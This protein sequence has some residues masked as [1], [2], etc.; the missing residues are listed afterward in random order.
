MKK[1]LLGLVGFVVVVCAVG[2]FVLF[3]KKPAQR[4]PSAETIAA[5]PELVARGRYLSENVLV[6]VH[7]HSDM[8]LDRW[9][10]SGDDAH[11]GAG[12][13]ALCW[14]E[15]AGVPGKI[16]PKNITP[17]RETGLGAWSDGEILRAI[18]EGV[19]RDGT[20]LFPIMPYLNYRELSDG[21]AHAVVAYLRT[22]PAVSR[23]V[24]PRELKFPLSV[25]VNFMPKPLDSMVAEPIR[26]D[27]VA[28]GK[29][30]AT[31]AGCKQC[32]TPVDERT[33]QIIEA[34][35][36]WGGQE[37]KHGTIGPVR[38]A[39]LTPHETGIG[40]RGKAQ[41]VAMF[42]SFADPSLRELKVDPKANTV[43][44]WGRYAGMTDADLSAIYDYLRTLPPAA[45]PIERRP[46][47]ALPAP[48]ADPASAAQVP[49]A[50]QPAAP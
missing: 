48:A 41:F 15:G 8:K 40:T 5:T 50:A 16:C 23:P 30:L 22:L 49:A 32:H 20:A 6:C 35:A 46:P 42:R 3:T 38:S 29:Y 34:K 37:F 31:V 19:S 36:F 11:V 43:M 13:A 9:G 17:D 28:H 18:R 12:S 24:P 26:T 45:N 39:N 14:D 10:M 2:A 7:C 4:P 25:I 21:D 27:P 47:P 1:V 33:H 44:P